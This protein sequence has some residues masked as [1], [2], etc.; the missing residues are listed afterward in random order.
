MSITSDSGREFAALQSHDIASGR[1]ATILEL[2]WDILGAG[3]SKGGKYLVVGVNEDARP[4]ARL[5][6]AATLKPVKLAGMPPGLVRGIKISRDEAA[7][8]FYASDGS[9]PDDLWA[10]AIGESPRRLTSALNPEIRRED[11]V[12][13]SVV[14][15]RA[16]PVPV[17]GP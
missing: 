6:D 3:Y 2:D 17:K 16:T 10:G 14:R 8:A 12:V 4:D 9:A 5:L 7:I 15:F 11:L 13:P 1:R